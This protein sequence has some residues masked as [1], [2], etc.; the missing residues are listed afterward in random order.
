MPR[1]SRAPAPQPESA[2]LPAAV[3]AT[4]E[5]RCC[6]GDNNAPLLLSGPGPGPCRGRVIRTPEEVCHSLNC[7]NRFRGNAR[8]SPAAK[9]PAGHYC[10]YLSAI[11]EISGGVAS[12]SITRPGAASETGPRLRSCGGP[13]PGGGVRGEQAARAA[14]GARRREAERR[15]L[16]GHGS[17]TRLLF[18]RKNCSSN[19]NSWSADRRDARPLSCRNGAATGCRL[20]ALLRVIRTTVGVR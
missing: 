13:Q 7:A 17:G 20:T 15:F 2:G 3:T 14:R 4:M 11:M 9:A 10:G 1:E 5:H 8:L 19:P 6:P 12:G 18:I 16:A